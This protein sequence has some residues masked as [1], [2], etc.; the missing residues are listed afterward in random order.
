M[1]ALLYDMDSSVNTLPS[2]I[3]WTLKILLERPFLDRGHFNFVFDP[4]IQAIGEGKCTTGVLKIW[5]LVKAYKN[6]F[7]LR[8][9]PYLLCYATYS[10]V[11]VILRQS[12]YDRAN[13]SECVPFFWSALLDLQQG[14]NAGLKKPLNILK[15][16]MKRLGADIPQLHVAANEIRSGSSL[17]NASEGG[18]GLAATGPTTTGLSSGAT[19]FGLQERFPMSDSLPI[20]DILESLELDLGNSEQWF[21]TMVGDEGG[22]MDDSM[23]GLFTA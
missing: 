20:A 14:C 22:L 18:L 10:A 2:A 21:D 9:A 12:Q 3:Y 8:R 11:L 6:T 23:Y 5:G 16:L 17:K 13:F 4:A 19:D 7:T 15:T 1:F